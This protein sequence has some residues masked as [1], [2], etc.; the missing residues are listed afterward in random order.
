MIGLIQQLGL[1]SIFESFQSEVKVGFKGVNTFC[2]N[3]TVQQTVQFFSLKTSWEY[4][5][6]TGLKFES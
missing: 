5:G 6:G 3:H 4:M 2:S 1:Y